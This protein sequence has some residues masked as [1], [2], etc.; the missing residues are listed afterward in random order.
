MSEAVLADQARPKGVPSFKV[1]FHA[2]GTLGRDPY[3]IYA[4]MRDAGPVVWLERY[5]YY[6]FPRFA[7]VSRA[8]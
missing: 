8:L 4:E 2:P 1:D 7:E 3:P 5:G 6:A